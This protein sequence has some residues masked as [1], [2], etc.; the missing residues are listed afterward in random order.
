MQLGSFK[1]FNAS[2][3]GYFQK[4]VIMIYMKICEV[5]TV[6]DNKEARPSKN[7]GCSEDVC[8]V[9]KEVSHLLDLRHLIFLKI[10]LY[11]RTCLNCKIIR[12]EN[13]SG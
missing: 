5:I 7:V 2:F 11:K 9:I 6:M 4:F 3:K 12:R 1:G 13:L 10:Y 8:H